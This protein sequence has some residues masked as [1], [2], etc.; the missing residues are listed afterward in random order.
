MARQDLGEKSPPL[1]PTNTGRTCR[2]WGL[3]R[4]SALIYTTPGF[5]F[6]P[7]LNSSRN[8]MGK[9][10]ALLFRSTAIGLVEAVA[11]AAVPACK[12]R[13]KERRLMH[14][15]LERGEILTRNKRIT[16][17]SQQRVKT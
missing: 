10:M 14:G 3:D 7:E 5:D 6:E 15:N 1:A 9:E 12:G 17:L 13:G 11:A 4:S 2:R 8:D 16:L